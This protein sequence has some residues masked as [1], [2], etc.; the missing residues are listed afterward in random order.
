MNKLQ[1]KLIIELLE[2]ASCEFSN[3]TCTDFEFDNTEENR[4]FVREVDK[5]Y[6]EDC[7]TEEEDEKIYIDNWLLMDYCADLLKKEYNL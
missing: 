1:A 6:D 3:H 2:L 7:E 5:Y 4:N